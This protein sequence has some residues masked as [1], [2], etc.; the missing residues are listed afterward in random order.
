MKHSYLFALVLGVTDGIFT[1]LTLASGRVINSAEPIGPSFAVRIA[2]AGSV[3]GLFVFF[4]AEYSRLRGELAYAARHLNLAARGK[5][6]T[7][8][9]GWTVLRDA[10][11]AALVS[12]GGSFAGA[13]LPLL[14]TGLFRGPSF[15]A[16]VVAIL[17]LGLLGV[18]VARTVYG[19]SLRWAAALMLTGGILTAVGIEL[20][21]T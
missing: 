7:T 18:S 3:S 14:L 8:R 4:V 17:A 15:M 12:S 20:H 6:A 21:I 9:L 5:L 13:L 11:Q 1:A 16:I 2:V 10:L 19:N